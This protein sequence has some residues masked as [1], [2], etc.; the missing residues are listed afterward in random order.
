MILAVDAGNTNIVLGCIENGEILSIA[1]L[2]SDIH[3]TEY[4]YAVSMQEI[5]AFQGI[6]CKGFEGAILSSVVWPL[7]DTLRKAIQLL[8]GKEAL[9][10]GKGLKTGLDI[11]IDDPAQVGADLVVGSVAALR[12]YKPPLVMVDMGTATTLFVLDAQGRFV[13]GSI[14]PGLRLSEEALSSGTSQLP[15][16]ALTAPKK[17]IGTNTVDCMQA[18][19]I[20]GTAAMLDGMIDRMEAELGYPVNVVATGGLAGVVAPFC[21]R[22]ILYD[23]DLLLKGLYILWEKNHKD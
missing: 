11:R 22:E 7:T 19:A 15:R 9:V 16:I 18:G 10:I 20:Y 14:H 3:K 4:E 6:N 23:P 17:C 1:R 8:T 5:L 13:G 12:Y 21:R 2:N